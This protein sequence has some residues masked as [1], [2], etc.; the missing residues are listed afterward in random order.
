MTR[1]AILD[2]KVVRELK[3]LATS[4]DPYDTITGTT[5]C[6][7]DFYEGPEHI[8][9]LPCTNNCCVQVRAGLTEHSATTQRRTKTTI[10]RV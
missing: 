1:P 2:K 7:E 10:W 9:L 4:D 5:M 6:A 3:A 8:R